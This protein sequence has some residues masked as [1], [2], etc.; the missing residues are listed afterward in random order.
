M[1]AVARPLAPRYG[2]AAEVAAYA[3]VS[4]KTVRRMIARGDVRGLKVGRRTVV[5]FEDL[6][7]HV[8]RIDPRTEEVPVMAAP[9]PTAAVPASPHRST[10]A[11]GRLLPRTEEEV[12]R[13][14]A[15]A[16]RAM[17]EL[18]AIGDLD[19]QDAT[20]AALLVALDEDPL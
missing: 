9:A 20:L 17:D 3:G 19:E 11:R 7:R 13:R 4:P 5:P 15:E 12:R 6:D 10:D 16:I 18:A 14:N 8:L 2:S 1:S